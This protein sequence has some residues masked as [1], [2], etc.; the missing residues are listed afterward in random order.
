MRRAEGSTTCRKEAPSAHADTR[1]MISRHIA[2]TTLVLFA[3]LSSA[4][5]VGCLSHTRDMSDAG[6]I[7]TDTPI[8]LSDC[9]CVSDAPRGACDPMIANG[10]GGCEVEIG[11]LWDGS[12]CRS[13]SG[14]ECVGRDCASLYVDQDSC[15]AAHTTCRRACGES[16]GGP[17][18]ACFA[19]EFCSYELGCGFDDGLGVCAPRPVGCRSDGRPVCGC[20]NVSYDNECEANLAGTSVLREGPCAPSPQFGIPMMRVSCGPADGPAW[21][22]TLTR[23]PIACESE[24]ADGVLLFEIWHELNTAPSE[25]TYTLRNDFAG[26]GQARV[27]LGGGGA[28]CD[29]MT[30]TVTIHGFATGEVTTFDYD[31]VTPDGLRFSA[32]NVEGTTWCSVLGPGCG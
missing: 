17:L 8:P 18:P 26:D 27:C 30:G 19:G 23:S 29:V 28:P 9:L 25:R 13:I 16:F 12:G 11:Y 32:T 5:L 1:P 20:D 22:F 15:M 31:L 10:V 21:A 14:C 7:A 4:G 3:A 2:Q 24:P 6:P